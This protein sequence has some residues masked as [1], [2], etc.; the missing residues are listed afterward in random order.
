MSWRAYLVET[1]SGLAYRSLEVDSFTWNDEINRIAGGRAVIRKES[2]KGLARHQYD[3]IQAS[4][5]L[6]YVRSD[7]TEVPW[8]GGPITGRP[9]ETRRT[10]TVEWSGMRHMMARRLAL[11]EGAV[12]QA[13]ATLQ[14]LIAT[15]KAATLAETT[16]KNAEKALSTA[17]KNYD[18]ALKDARE[19]AGLTRTTGKS[20]IQAGTPAGG[21]AYYWIRTSDNEPHAWGTS[22]YVAKTTTAARSAAAT[23]VARLNTRNA[24]Q[25]TLDAAKADET[26]KIA[27]AETLEADTEF[28][29]NVRFSGTTLGGVMWG[30]IGL[31]QTKPG[32]RLPIVRGTPSEIGTTTRTYQ[33]W[34]LAN[35][36]VDKLLTELSDVIDGPDIHF[37]P[38]WANA[39]QT[40]FEWEVVHGTKAQPTIAQSWTPDWDS[41][42]ERSDVVEITISNDASAVADRVYAT[43]AGQGAG[44]L[45]AQATNL[46]RVQRGR[47]FLEVVISESDQKEIGPLAERARGRLAVGREP[48]DQLTLEVRADSRKNPLGEWR[49]GDAAKVTLG[50]EWEHIPAG[51]YLMRII[52]ASGDLTENVTLE[53]QE[54]QWYPTGT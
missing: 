49:V 35:L 6:C 43:G 38:R 47:P 15:R 28:D 16:R 22:S 52:K 4:L 13:Q 23:A 48:Y 32:G 41:A 31:A 27:L 10:L 1:S 14:N 53:M 37:R 45:I 21:K 42:A 39:N 51:T 29:F 36:S 9:S 2:L 40:R 26:A 19:A 5:V 54:D 24:A 3:V 46:D 20:F 34:N 50:D 25:S 44:T 12:A 11:R 7:G 33:W 30:L 8:V 17:T 18:E